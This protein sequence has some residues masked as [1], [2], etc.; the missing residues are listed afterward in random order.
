MSITSGKGTHRAFFVGGGTFRGGECTSRCC[1]AC[2][3]S[4]TILV[5]TNR[6]WY[7]G[8]ASGGIGF[9][10]GWTYVTGVL[11][12]CG[13]SI[14]FFEI[15]TDIGF[16][17]FMFSTDAYTWIVSYVCVTWICDT[18][19]SWIILV[20]TKGGTNEF[21]IIT[22]ILFTHV[23]WRVSR[24]VKRCFFLYFFMF[25]LNTND[26]GIVSGACP[27]SIRDKCPLIQHASNTTLTK[28]QTIQ[29]RILLAILSGRRE[30]WSSVGNQHR[31]LQY[32][33]L[34]FVCQDTIVIII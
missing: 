28:R 12:R 25:V 30:R 14:F 27:G 34:A 4:N 16:G 31:W 17:T 2:G 9:V 18:T 32:T 3:G 10:T 11:D 1:F 15:H 13:C 6:T 8:R 33:H 24:C 22:T 19:W 7:T 29:D 23:F 20:D 5:F 26:I 21:R